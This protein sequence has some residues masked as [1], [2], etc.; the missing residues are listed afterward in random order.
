[1]IRDIIRAILTAILIYLSYQETGPWTALCLVFIAARLEI[2]TFFIKKIL[3]YCNERLPK[4]E[5]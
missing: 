3:R 2:D 5:N 4:K 1:M